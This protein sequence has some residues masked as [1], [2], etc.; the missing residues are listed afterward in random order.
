MS[1]QYT[2]Q[3]LHDCIML[4]IKKLDNE[5]QVLSTSMRYW[6]SRHLEKFV[7]KA[8]VK[9]I[10]GQIEHGGDIRNRD[11]LADLAQEHTDSFW[12]IA[13]EEDKKQ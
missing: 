8:I 13:V 9:F 1:T 4:E 2:P 11:T 5:K 3:A 10:K 12:Y 7:Y 6:M